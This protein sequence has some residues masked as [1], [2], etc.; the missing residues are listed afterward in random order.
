[1]SKAKLAQ[2]LVEKERRESQRHFYHIFP[3]EGPLCRDNYPRH[4]EFIGTTK[5]YTECAFICGNQVGKTQ[6]AAFFI[7]AAM[8]GDYPEWWHGKRWDHAVDCWAAGDTN[9]TVRNIIQEALL[10]PPEA[11]GYGR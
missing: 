5:N 11:I 9:E 8:T 1:M 7:A 3:D 4:M 2:M 6:L 10:G